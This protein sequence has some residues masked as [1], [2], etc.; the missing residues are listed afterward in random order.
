MTLWWLDGDRNVSPLNERQDNRR[1][2]SRRFFRLRSP[3]EEKRVVSAIMH[4][5][6]IITDDGDKQE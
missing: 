4:A 3:V 2:T 6:L 5:P 1:F